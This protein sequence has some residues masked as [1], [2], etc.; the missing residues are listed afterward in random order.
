MLILLPIFFL[1]VGA[2]TTLLGLVP[3]FRLAGLLSNVF[4]G[5]AFVILLVGFFFL[6]STVTVSKWVPVD[7]FGAGLELTQNASAWLLGVAFLVLVI[8]VLARYNADFQHKPLFPVFAGLLAAA[9]ALFGIMAD[10]FST[11]VL[12]WAVLDV[13]AFISF[14]LVTIAGQNNQDDIQ[15]RIGRSVFALALNLAASVMVLFAA[16]ITL[17]QGTNGSFSVITVPAQASTF[18]VIASLLRLSAYPFPVVG[19]EG[20]N[21]PAEFGVLF[22]IA[23][24]VLAV[25]V[26]TLVQTL[27]PDG[28]VKNLLITAACVVVIIA[29]FQFWALRERREG[30]PSV[31]LAYSGLL[32]LTIVYAGEM[33]SVAVLSSAL[34]MIFGSSALFFSQNQPNNNFLQLFPLLGTVILLGA[35]FTV[36]FIGFWLTFAGIL[37][38]GNWLVLLIFVLSQT[39]L[40]AGYLRVVFNDEEEMQSSPTLV[41]VVLQSLV[42]GVPAFL[43]IAFGLS[44][45]MLGRFIGQPNTPG[46]LAVV[47]QAG[48]MGVVLVVLSALAAVAIWYFDHFARSWRETTLFDSLRVRVKN[49]NRQ[50][51]DWIDGAR[52]VIYTTGSILEGDGGEIW[53]LLIALLIWLLFAANQ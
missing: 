30:F 47:G 43:G 49:T 31:L 15:I 12:A 7:M 37:K 51:G 34:A 40:L 14:A 22:R 27:E 23:P 33:R 19:G 13:I 29:A 21:F 38:A 48:V 2:F 39:M 25:K 36:G 35:P 28:W 8:A 24:L 17:N 1:L 18:L 50:V 6:P 41:A 16:L 45:S 44:P 26:L 42:V 10:S 20:G 53:A 32:M 4:S 11:L 3:S 52:S 5:I 9:A 46:F